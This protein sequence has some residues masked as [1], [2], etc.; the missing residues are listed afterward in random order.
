MAAALV[1]LCPPR[2]TCLAPLIVL[3]KDISSP[4]TG[5]FACFSLQP[6]LIWFTLVRHSLPSPVIFIRIQTRVV[7]PQN[8]RHVHH[9]LRR[10]CDV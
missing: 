9:G 10:H 1:T 7:L 5:T 8:P 2:R 6:N 3:Y 4:Y